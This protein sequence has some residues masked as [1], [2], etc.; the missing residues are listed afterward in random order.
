[1]NR[2]RLLRLSFVIAALIALALV[3]RAQE[4]S[5]SPPGTGDPSRTGAS[6]AQAARAA[7]Q[8]RLGMLSGGDWPAAWGGWSQDARR[9]VPRDT[10]VRA[11]RTCHPLLAVPLQ[12]VQVLPIDPG[13]VDVRW[14]GGGL[15]GTLRMVSE[16]RAWRVAPTV[17]QLS[18]YAEGPDAAVIELRRRGECARR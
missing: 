10:Y 9:E 12:V 8:T 13:T 5:G 2:A 17:T 15:S 11:H 6:S 1:M 7:A 3:S 14:R 4:V 16:G 18:P